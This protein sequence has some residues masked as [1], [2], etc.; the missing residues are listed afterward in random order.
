M[1]RSS[2]KLNTCCLVS[3][4]L[5][6]HTLLPH[7]AMVQSEVRRS[8]R[9][10]T[11]PN[12]DFEKNAQPS[13]CACTRSPCGSSRSAPPPFYLKNTATTCFAKNNGDCPKEGEC[14]SIS[15][16]GQ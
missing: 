3:Y 5:H 13:S 16:I 2:F 11:Y 9:R 12:H 1:I 4:V 14:N 10:A 8:T 15:K 6:L 7:G